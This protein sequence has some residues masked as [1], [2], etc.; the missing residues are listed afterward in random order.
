M[1][2]PHTQVL[3]KWIAAVLILCI[4][5]GRIVRFHSPCLLCR[6]ARSLT[7]V[8]KQHVELILQIFVVSSHFA[9]RSEHSVL[10]ISS[11]HLFGALIRTSDAWPRRG[12]YE[13][14]RR[15]LRVFMRFDFLSFL[16]GTEI[17][18]LL[19]KMRIEPLLKV[20]CLNKQICN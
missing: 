7:E 9:V 3:W 6:S 10:S 11:F 5:S 16:F 20:D 19:C 13:D 14:S 17:C 18:C 15:V 2:S 4:L 8:M 12:T 1:H